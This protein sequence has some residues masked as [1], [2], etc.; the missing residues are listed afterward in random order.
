[1]GEPT[2]FSPSEPESWNPNDEGI[3]DAMALLKSTVCADVAPVATA[4]PAACMDW[5]L[6]SVMLSSAMKDIVAFELPVL[7]FVTPVKPSVN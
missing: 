6:G 1:M 4:V 3:D 5:A 7:P 2:E